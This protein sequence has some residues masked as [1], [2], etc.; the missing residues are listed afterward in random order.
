MAMPKYHSKTLNRDFDCV[1]LNSLD[2]SYFDQAGGSLGLAFINRGIT[3]SGH[4]WTTGSSVAWNFTTG[5]EYGCY[6]APG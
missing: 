4:G 1:I 3:G 6:A 5:N 2:A